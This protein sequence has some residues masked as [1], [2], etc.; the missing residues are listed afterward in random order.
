VPPVTQWL[1]IANVAVYLLQTS[2]MFSPEAFA[3]WPPGGFESAFEPWQL[4][5][6]AFLH[7]NTAHIFFNMLA[8]YMFGGEV[9]RLFGSR[10]YTQYYFACVVSAAICPLVV[11][12]LMG[13]PQVPMVGASG[14]IYGLV[15][16]YGIYVPH[17]R[18]MLLF[19]PIPMPARVFVFGFAALE[20]ILGVTQ[21][22]AGVAH[23]AHIGGMI[24]GWLMIQY[25]R[26][27]FP[28]KL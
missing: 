11:T 17:R 19:P 25:R 26:R 4:V 16:A 28:F 18:V 1:L 22:A 10:F 12:A 20:V 13:A 23:F 14:G 5:T 9:E 21:T 8:L 3:L 7:A 6:Y 27:G 15:L 24:G 2:G